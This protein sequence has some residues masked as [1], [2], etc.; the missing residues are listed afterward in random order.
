MRIVTLLSLVTL[1][2]VGCAT[3]PKPQP[4]PSATPA[5]A[6]APAPAPEPSPAPAQKAQSDDI[7]ALLK[8]LAIHFDFDKADLTSDSQ[9]RLDA[10]AD[11][12]RSHKDVHIKVEGNCDELGTT[13]YNIALGQRR[14]DAVR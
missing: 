8:G 2:S 1:V 12:M 10:L 11:A 6:P 14:A 7:G 5:P 3:A 4:T 13:E 9:H